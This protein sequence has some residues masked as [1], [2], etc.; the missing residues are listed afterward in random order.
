MQIQVWNG[1]KYKFKNPCPKGMSYLL[2]DGHCW[3]CTMFEN[4][5]DRV[6]DRKDCPPAY[7]PLEE[8]ENY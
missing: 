3:D 6:E 8:G 5:K 1:K 7:I 2:R 4:C